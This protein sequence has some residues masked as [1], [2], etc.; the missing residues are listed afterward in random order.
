MDYPAGYNP[1]LRIGLDQ[2]KRV[3]CDGGQSTNTLRIDLRDASYVSD[4][5]D[6]LGLI[7]YNPGTDEVD[8]TQVY[9]V[10]TDDPQYERYFANTTP[11]NFNEFMLPIGKLSA[12]VGE[13]YEVGGGFDNH[14]DLGFFLDEQQLAD[15]TTFTFSPREGYYYTF[16][17]HFEEKTGG[18]EA[19][20]SCWGSFPVTMKVVPE[21]LVW[22]DKQAGENG[23]ATG[24][25][26]EDGNW[27]RASKGDLHKA[28]TDNT[29]EE[30]ADGDGRAFTPM[31]FS[32]IVMPRL[33]LIHI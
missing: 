18:G 10:D 32:K 7:D 30:Y 6:R 2:I 13:E 5:V 21:Y 23:V 19:T 11:E 22:D 24:N 8:Y 26:H 27:R 33:S 20:T 28:Q 17:V 1:A 3:K 31:L 15:G 16:I 14:A 4:G 25:W 29:Y 9:L 12:L